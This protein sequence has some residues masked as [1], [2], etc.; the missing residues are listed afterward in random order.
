MEKATRPG[1]E[2]LQSVSDSQKV[3]L[4]FKLFMAG[5]VLLYL[6]LVRNAYMKEEVIFSYETVILL[7]LSI[8]IL[9]MASVSLSFIRGDYR[10]IKHVYR[11]W[12][13]LVLLF[14]AIMTFYGLTQGNAQRDIIIDVILFVTLF[15]GVING[16]DRR[17]WVL[18]DKFMLGFFA[19]NTVLVIKSWFDAMGGDVFDPNESLSLFHSKYYFFV[20]EL[21]IWPYFL[22]TLR[23]GSLYRKLIS[24]SGI[25]IY[26]IASLTLAKRSPF[27]LLFLLIALSLFKSRLRMDSTR[28]IKSIF[29]K[30]KGAVIAGLASAV[31]IFSLG[32]SGRFWDAAEKLQERFFLEGNMVETVFSDPRI[33]YDSELVFGHF[34]NSEILF[35]QGMGAVAGV[36]DVG[37]TGEKSLSDEYVLHN[38]VLLLIQKGGLLFLFVW[39]WGWFV[40]LKDFL[41]SREPYMNRYFLPVGIVFI[42]SFVTG[43]VN[44]GNGFAFLMMC[45]GMGM[46]RKAERIP[47]APRQEKCS[48]P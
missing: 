40:F 24:Y 44:W 37:W 19:L 32:I 6:D 48:I 18:F 42:F 43:F 16:C 5:F 47:L 35:G 4:P 14:I 34:S 7:K 10:R 21:T 23:D 39:L 22:L 11:L 20:G 3:R 30:I 15:A 26:F 31:V 2:A 17:N 33:S 45:A 1:A 9:F 12:L 38:G 29:S 28:V 36:A 13:S 46:A 25:A 8:L 27:V 41:A